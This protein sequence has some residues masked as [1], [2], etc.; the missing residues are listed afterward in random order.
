MALAPNK[1]AKTWKIYFVN[2]FKFQAGEGSTN[3]KTCYN[4]GVWVKGDVG[5]G[6][7]ESDYYGV[8]KEVVE[9]QYP[10][11]PMHRVV[12]FLHEWFNPGR[13]TRKVHL[14]YRI[15]EAK[16]DWWAIIYTK[17]TTRVEVPD[18]LELTFQNDEPL[19][20]RGITFDDI[21]VPLI[22]EQGVFEILD[23]SSITRGDRAGT[24]SSNDYLT[25]EFCDGNEKDEYE[26]V[27]EVD[28]GES[29]PDNQENENDEE[30]D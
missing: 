28:L 30:I 21:E 22:D 15:V 16:E 25:M 1:K 4:S 9:L 12:L 11:Q 26:N 8:M 27:E 23:I 13:G 17:A 14:E 6:A 5:E 24:S 7:G 19:R 2:G 18:A 3:K 29:E 20:V 10:M